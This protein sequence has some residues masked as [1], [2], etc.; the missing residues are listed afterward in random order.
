MC[1]PILLWRYVCSI[2]TSK[3]KTKR[4][5]FKYLLRLLISFAVLYGSGKLWGREFQ[6]RPC[7][8]YRN[9]HNQVIS[10]IIVVVVFTF[11]T[12]MSWHLTQNTILWPLFC[13]NTGIGLCS[14]CSVF[15]RL[16]TQFRLTPLSLCIPHM[17]LSYVKQFISRKQNKV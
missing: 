12:V 10:I 5:F 9:G 15:S 13:P 4:F 2:N 1:V 17:Y 6:Y 3:F 7:Y 14:W 16:P 11:P 8:D